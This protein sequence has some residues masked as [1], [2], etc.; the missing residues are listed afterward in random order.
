MNLAFSADISYRVNPRIAS[1]IRTADSVVIRG[2]GE[3]FELSFTLFQLLLVFAEQKTVQ[4]AFDSLDV[5]VGLSQFRGIVADFL[6]HGL[7]ERDQ[8][9]DDAHDLQQLLNPGIFADPAMVD[10]LRTW[11]RQ[12]RA[13]VIPDALPQDFAEQVHRDL[14]LSTRWA[15]VEGGH[16]F[17][18][19]R[20]SV[21]SD[22]ASQTPTLAECS[23]RFRSAAT[24]RFVADLTG[25]DCSGQPHVAGGWYRPGEYALPHDDSGLKGRS[26][27]YVWYLTKEWRQEW[28]GAFFWC[29]TGQY[30]LPG[31]NALMI[32]NVMP[33]NVHLVC[34]VAPIATS[35]RI[36]I[37]GF[38]SCSEPIPA[39]NPVEPFALIS[40]CAYGQGSAKDLES[41]PFAVL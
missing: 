20:T 39:Q 11:L 32:F 40:P 25:R 29:Q 27:A 13:V 24:R 33:S 21:I 41:L 14:S 30:V 6:D 23:R 1:S 36:T 4:Q 19:F 12:G 5:D 35:K 34:P 10:R 38:W 15:V 37:N 2:V 31:F 7:L 26:V 22:I 16:D 17:F 9:D 8:P 18:H 3:P 28:G